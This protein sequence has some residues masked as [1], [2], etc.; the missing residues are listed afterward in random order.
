MSYMDDLMNIS[1]VYINI[2]IVKI[3]ENK[4]LLFI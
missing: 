1:T 2:N 3:I 4:N